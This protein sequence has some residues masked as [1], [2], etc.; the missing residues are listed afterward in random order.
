[1]YVQTGS[2]KG[3]LAGLFKN[4]RTDQ[5]A[6]IPAVDI[7]STLPDLSHLRWVLVIEKEVR[8]T[9]AQADLTDLTNHPNSGS[10]QQSCGKAISTKCYHWSRAPCHGKHFLRFFCSSTNSDNRQKGTRTSGPGVSCAP[11]SIVPNH[12]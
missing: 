11:F 5:T 9:N 8:E 3:L 2:P 4:D 6:T 12:P 10:I 1:M 7:G